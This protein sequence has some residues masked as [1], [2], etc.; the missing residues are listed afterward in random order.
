M[1][2]AFAGRHDDQPAGF[3]I[4][5]IRGSNMA[6]TSL[7]DDLLHEFGEE[8]KMIQEQIGLFNPLAVSL[9]KP[10]AQRLAGA[11][12]ILF[13]ELLCWALFLT[14]IAMCIFLN[15]L[16]PFYLLFQ[17]SGPEHLQAFGM[18][19][20]QLLQWSVYA[21]IGII[22]L[23]FLLLAG[24]LARIRRKNAILHLTGSR[25]KTLVGQHLNRKAAIE[26]IEQRHFNELPADAV[27]DVKTIPNPGYDA[28]DEVVR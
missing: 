2:A 17:L 1:L 27:P 22:G 14:A 10:A 21:L 3:L 15:K 9:R 12:L 24:S 18:Q 4:M 20:V 25:I 26:A 16:Y 28:G 13:G 7:Q 8:K 11:G 19:N 23:L 6:V 5:L